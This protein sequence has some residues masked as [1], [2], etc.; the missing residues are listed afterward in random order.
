[1]TQLPELAVEQ[2]A[3]VSTLALSDDLLALVHSQLEPC[4]AASGTVLFAEGDPAER[5]YIVRRGDVRLVTTRAGDGR[6]ST[7]RG[8]GEFIGESALIDGSPHGATAVCD[9]DCEFFVLSR[10]SLCRIFTA[11]AGIA[12]RILQVLMARARQSDRERLQEAESRI[13]EL[14]TTNAQ[15]ST[16]AGRRERVVAAVPH[17]IIVTDAANRILAANPAAERLF[18]HTTRSDLWAWVVPVDAAARADTEAKLKS[19]ASW[20]GE[21]ELVTPDGRQLPCRITAVS[22]SDHGST[23]MRVWMIEDQ[24][25]QRVAEYQVR[26]QQY[27]SAKSEMGGEIAHEVNN[28]LAVLS[29]N[30]ELLPMYLGESTSPKVERTVENIR[31]TVT[32]MS[33]FTEGL[34]RSRH[35]VGERTEVEL[36]PFLDHEI[37]FLHPQKLFKRIAITTDWGDDVPALICD[38]SALQH[39]LYILLRNAAETLTAAGG[40]DHTVALS[41]RFD[42]AQETVTWTIADD[43]PGIP[44]ELVPRLFRE[45]VTTKEG[46]RGY[47][48]LIADRLIRAQGGTITATP[49]EGGGTQVVITL[50]CAA[51][52]APSEAAA[53]YA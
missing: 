24:S 27:L 11:H 13:R 36:T 29:G 22:I 9:T 7:R 23:D 34:L 10:E 21:I 39:V 43:G 18:G 47:G 38:P 6:D 35:P 19:G 31:R 53:T 45:R 33:I 8:R 32:Q 44:E 15:L 16:L 51:V 48:L 2:V 37:V 49:R 14:E 52:G 30:A 12:Q 42:P 1:M 40:P 26:E 5:V 50:P 3:D 25:G 17:P 41:T 28:H 46:D 4:R 20:R